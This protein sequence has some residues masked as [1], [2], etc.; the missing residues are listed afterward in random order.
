MKRSE[1]H[2]L[3]RRLEQL[4]FAY[5]ISGKG[6][7]KVYDPDGKLVSVMPNSTSDTR[8]IR[9]QKAHLKRLGIVLT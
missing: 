3:R 8:A 9:N 7:W 4:G 1:W 5:R 2:E 6:H